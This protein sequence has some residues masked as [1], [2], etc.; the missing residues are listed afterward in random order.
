MNNIYKLHKCKILISM[1]I[2]KLE[3]KTLL[4]F[5]SLIINYSDNCVYIIKL[6]YYIS[7]Q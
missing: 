6:Y 4:N 1:N 5:F 7:I 2:F 3:T